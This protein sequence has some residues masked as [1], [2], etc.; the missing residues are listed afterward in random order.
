MFG[1]M[2]SIHRPDIVGADFYWAKYKWYYIPKY[3][4]STNKYYEQQIKMVG[5]GLIASA[6][7]LLVLSIVRV[8]I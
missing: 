1:G 2:L 4:K 3:K 6:V 8:N 7:I 5:V